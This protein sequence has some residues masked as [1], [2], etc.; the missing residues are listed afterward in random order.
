MSVGR[1]AGLACG[2]FDPAP[3]EFDAAGV[4]GALGAVVG[5][6][7]PVVDEHDDALLALAVGGEE[8]GE[9]LVELRPPIVEESMVAEAIHSPTI[10]QPFAWAYSRHA[11]RRSCR[12][13]LVR[14][15]WRS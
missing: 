8:P 9:A 2:G 4:D 10:G 5:E 14:V 13:A 3:G 12:V 15:A 7:V 1:F 11:S 6:A